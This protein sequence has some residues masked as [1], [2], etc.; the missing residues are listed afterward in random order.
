MHD[1]A[2]FAPSYAV[3][4]MRIGSWRWVR[5]PDCATTRYCPPVVYDPHEVYVFWIDEKMR[6][7]TQAARRTGKAFPESTKVINPDQLKAESAA[8]AK[9]SAPPPKRKPAKP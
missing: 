3:D 9:P 1:E 8:P 5:W 7:E 4:F 6:A 2:I